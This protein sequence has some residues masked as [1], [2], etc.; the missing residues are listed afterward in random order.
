[1]LK[2]TIQ[3]QLKEKGLKLSHSGTKSYLCI[4]TNDKPKEKLNSKKWEQSMGV[5]RETYQKQGG[6]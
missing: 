3:I 6:V 2:R 5:N 4:K 1:M